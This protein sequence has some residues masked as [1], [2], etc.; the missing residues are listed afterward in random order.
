VTQLY[1]KIK[2]NSKYFY[3]NEWAKRKGYGLPFAVEIE[4]TSDKYCVY[5]ADNQYYIADLNF[6]VLVDG[7]Y[8][9]LG[10]K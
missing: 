4:N 2:K 3:Q 7:Q 10:G 9:K 6:F 5:G 1:A 8:L